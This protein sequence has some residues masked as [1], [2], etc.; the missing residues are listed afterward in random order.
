[1]LDLPRLSSPGGTNTYALRSTC[2][3]YRILDL[4]MAHNVKILILPR[5]KNEHR[6]DGV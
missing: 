2:P 5:Q 4:R 1:M 3:V 6:T